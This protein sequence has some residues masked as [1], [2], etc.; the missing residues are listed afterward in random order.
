M[1]PYLFSGRYTEVGKFNAV[2]GSAI[3][4]FG[5]T[6][7]ILGAFKGY[8]TGKKW[9][10]TGITMLLNGTVTTAIAYFLGVAFE[11]ILVK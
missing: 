4:L 1:L 8:L 2:F 3:A 5:V 7:F 10:K 6:L 11:S 9:Y